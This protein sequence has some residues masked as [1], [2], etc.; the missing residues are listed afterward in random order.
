MESIEII[1][2]DTHEAAFLWS[3]PDVEFEKV[4]SKPRGTSGFTVFF[5]FRAVVTKVQLATIRGDFYNEKSLVE[6]KKYLKK[7]E[8]VNNILHEALRNCREK[9][10]TNGS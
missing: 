10:R 1:T 7:L 3:Q 9:E 5:V 8:D 2:R 4:F 6:P